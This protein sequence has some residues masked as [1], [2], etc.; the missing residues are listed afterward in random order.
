MNK[1]VAFNNRTLVLSQIQIQRGFEKIARL[2]NQR[3]YGLSAVVI[4]VVPGGMFFAADLMRKLTFD[5]AV[6]TVSCPHTPGDVSNTSAVNYLNEIDIEHRHVIVV[7]DAL[8]SGSTMKRIVKHIHD[9]HDVQSLSVCTL[10]ARKGHKSVGADTEYAYEMEN[11]SL[12]IGYGL[13][14]NTLYRNLPNVSAIN[15]NG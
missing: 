14:L 12:L 8:E 11:E 9:H 10:F 7:D 5:V 13:S 3:F 1:P 15:T 4:V 2:L 6:D